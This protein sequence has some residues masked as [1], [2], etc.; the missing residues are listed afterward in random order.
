MAMLTK[1]NDLLYKL[2]FLSNNRNRESDIA[3]SI[4]QLN[5]VAKA[6]GQTISELA[7]GDNPKQLMPSDWV[8]MRL[9][10]SLNGKLYGVAGAGSNNILIYDVEAKTTQTVTTFTD[11]SVPQKVIA[12]TDSVW[13]VE[14]ELSNVRKLFRTA[15]AGATFQFIQNFNTGITQSGLLSSRSV[16]QTPNGDLYYVDY[17]V[18]SSRTPGGANDRLSV[19]KSTNMG[20]TWSVVATFNTDGVKSDFRHFHSIRYN[21][22]NGYLYL[23]V[24]DGDLDSGII[25][26]NPK[27]TL[28]SNTPIKQM[29][30]S[31]DLRTY[32]Y[33]QTGRGVDMLFDEDNI[34]WL[35]DLDTN[36]NG[37]IT[38]FYTAKADL[39]DVKRVSSAL[40]K[41]PNLAGWYG[42]KMPSGHQ[43]WV[44]G[45]DVA[46]S[47]EKYSGI[48]CTNKEKTKM[49]LVGK[50]CCLTGATTIVPYGLEVVGD[51]AYYSASNPAGKA[52]ESTAGFYLMDEDYRCTEAYSSPDTIHPV[53]WVSKASGS[54]SNSGNTP[55]LA[56]QTLSYAVTGNRIPISATVIIQD[57]FY[58]YND[59]AA[60]DPV[61]NSS[62]R[63]GDVRVPLCIRGYGATKTEITGNSANSFSSLALVPTS[64]TLKL[65]FKDLT[66]NNA[67]TNA[68]TARITTVTGASELIYTRCIVGDYYLTTNN[69][70]TVRAQA[71]TVRLNSSYLTTPAAGTGIDMV[72]ASLQLINSAV[73]SGGNN[74][75]FSGT[76]CSLYSYK[77]IL[78]GSS[79]AAIRFAAGTTLSSD[80]V[81]FMFGG[82]YADANGSQVAINDLASLSLSGVVKGAI[83]AIPR[84][85]SVAAFD[86][87]CVNLPRGAAEVIKSDY[88]F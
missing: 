17:N 56:F 6:M 57:V 70:G 20:A 61:I 16:C 49:D 46:G 36:G 25:M 11:A 10:S 85:A 24:G 19:N 51:T 76:G 71:G 83:L 87:Y 55:A 79:A 35:V 63:Q 13:L 3:A 73:D 72:G 37:A 5:V 69:V 9:T 74:L 44:S 54:N 86:G 39:S 26:W 12:I 77:S 33:G 66:I 65:E 21:P 28:P 41:S 4:N 29:A 45:T 53:Y 47:N 43:V 40:T 2:K 7:G 18:N 50:F 30:Q 27:T 88:V 31:A 59:A 60:I 68:Y 67:K 34:Y 38:G 14:S 81:N 15:D 78:S 84:G 32:Q 62:L 64:Y 75:N 42:A 1:I 58:D 48:F 22:H 23:Q 52:A 8:G 80:G 82:M